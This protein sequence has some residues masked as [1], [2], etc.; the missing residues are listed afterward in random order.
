[1]IVF[2]AIDIRAGF[3]VRLLRGNYNQETV[4]GDDPVEMAKRFKEQGATHLHVID[5]D[6]AR[7]GTGENLRAIERIA[8]LGMKVQTG[9]GIRTQE[10]IQKRLEIGAFRIV[11]GTAAVEN[12]ELVQWAVGRYNSAIA[13]GIDAKGC[14]VSVRGWETKSQITPLQ[15]GL[16]MKQIGVEFAIFTQIERDGTMEGADIRVSAELA[17][18]TGLNIVVSG[19]VGTIGDIKAAKEAGMYGIIIGKALYEGSIDLTQALAYQK[20]ED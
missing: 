14:V 20:T 19:G 5:L 13:V 3:C 7:S 16:Q 15:L 10:D 12:P 17:K 4:Y 8:K 2:P 11:I 6:G 1:M 18:Q 9:G